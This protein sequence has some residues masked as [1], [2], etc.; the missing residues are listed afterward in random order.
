MFATLNIQ[1]QS[2]SMA[3]SIARLDALLDMEY[4]SGSDISAHIAQLRKGG[5]LD[6]DKLHVVILLQTMPK[7]KEWE[8]TITALKMIEEGILTKKKTARTLTEKA[9]ELSLEKTS[10][11]Q[12]NTAFQ[13]R[14][15]SKISCFGCGK[16]GVIRRHCEH[17]QKQYQQYRNQQNT[18]EKPAPNTDNTD[19]KLSA[20]FAFM[21]K[22]LPEIK[23]NWYVDSEAT[24]HYTVRTLNLCP[25]YSLLVYLV[26]ALYFI[27]LASLLPEL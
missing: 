12:K 27:V 26:F 19:K 10:A 11:E 8:S 9:R 17:C 15:S 25:Y 21:T 20:H 22:V 5:Q 23:E 14:N 24:R 6:M 1:Y 13:T 16:K 18:Q 4:K 2:I 7:L 3:S